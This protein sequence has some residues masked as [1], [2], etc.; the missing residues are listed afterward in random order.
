MHIHVPKVVRNALIEKSTELI[1]FLFLFEGLFGFIIDDG[2]QSIQGIVAFS[3][4]P[5]PELA[6]GESLFIIPDFL[7]VTVHHSVIENEFNEVL[8]SDIQFRCDF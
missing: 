6:Q 2:Q 3:N 8:N 4:G 7:H 5:F 1:D